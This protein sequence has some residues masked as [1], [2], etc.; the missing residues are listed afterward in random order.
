MKKFL[1]GILLLLVLLLAGCSGKEEGGNK[2]D[3][4]KSGVSYTVN[5]VT[6]VPGEDFAPMYEKL[7]EPVVYTEAASCYFDGMD[8]VF[9]YDGFEVR[10]YPAE[11]GK[12]IVQDLCIST[13]AYSTE[14]GITVGSPIADVINAY[15]EDYSLTG[16]MYKYY[17]DDKSYTYFF[18][19]NDCVK[20]FGYAVD[21]AN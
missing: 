5:D 6:I 15:G 21:A 1:P 19:M 17:A 14:E 3:D 10:T 8:K 18:I 11:G 2:K 4:D 20:Y 16:K 7:G 13:T 9:T 12:D